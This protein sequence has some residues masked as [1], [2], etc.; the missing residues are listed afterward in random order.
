MPM[1]YLP[2]FGTIAN[3]RKAAIE[4]GSSFRTSASFL[5]PKNVNVICAVPAAVASQI[6]ICSLQRGTG[7]RIEPLL[8]FRMSIGKREAARAIVIAGWVINDLPTARLIR[9]TTHI[10]DEIAIVDAIFPLV[11]KDTGAGGTRSDHIGH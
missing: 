7:A 5:H 8:D 10:D 4:S 2:A 9:V 3:P 6:Q 1:G 11:E